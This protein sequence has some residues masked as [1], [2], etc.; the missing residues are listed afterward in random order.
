M[1]CLSHREDVDEAV[2]ALHNLVEFYNHL[3]LDSTYRVVARGILENLDKMTDVT[4]YDVVE[5]TASSRTTVWRMV[6]KM[7]YRSFTEFRYALQAA[8][9]Q[10]T[11][12]NR[13]LPA[14]YT[15][16]DRQIVSAFARQLRSSADAMER[17]F[18]QE[19]LTALAELL[20]QARR[21]SFYLP[22]RFPSI[23]SMQINLAMGGK[24][25]SCCMLI[26]DMLAD[27][28][29]LDGNSLVWFSPVEVSATMDMEPVFRLV[30]ER[31]A[32]I[33]LTADEHSRY[34]RYADELLFAEMNLP[35]NTRLTGLEFGI[36]ALSEVYRRRYI[37]KQL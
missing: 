9:G 11:Y 12:Y 6:Q 5:L 25:T 13:P 2:D 30:R 14:E 26:P 23:A 32:G 21:V 7:G 15:G 8:V 20:N 34:A 36:Y 24:Q 1:I 22:F 3:P 29:S 17:Y 27:A 37:E 4:I 19:R 31:G 16:S 28:A 33:L 18:T 35:E 10:Y